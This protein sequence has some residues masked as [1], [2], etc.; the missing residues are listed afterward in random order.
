M[1]PYASVLKSEVTLRVPGRHREVAA[2]ITTMLM[3]PASVG[4]LLWIGGLDSDLHAVTSFLVIGAGI[5]TALAGGSFLG[6]LASQEQRLR[7]TWL[8]VLLA[9]VGCFVVGVVLAIALA[10]LGMAVAGMMVGLVAIIPAL[11][12]AFFGALLSGWLLK[13]YEAHAL[14]KLRAAHWRR[15]MPQPKLARLDGA[16]QF[17]GIVLAPLGQLL[18]GVIFALPVFAIFG[19]N[20]LHGLLCTFV[21]GGVTG[22]LGAIGLGTDREFRSRDI[23]WPL[24][25]LPCILSPVA[26][27]LVPWSVLPGAYLVTSTG[28]VWLGAWLTSIA[29]LRKRNGVYA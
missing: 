29:M 1:T 19:D 22:L 7:S 16:D 5:P 11:T 20:D 2:V 3:L 8:G 25:A 17:G 26:F 14:R 28:G 23:I 10:E 6:P 15:L 4:L 13:P 24:V 12:G 21:S 27:L 18:F 9:C